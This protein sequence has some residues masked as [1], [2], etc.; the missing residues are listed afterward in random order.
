MT[1]SDIGY[2]VHIVSQFVAASTT[3][4]WATALQMF[5]VHRSAQ[6]QSLFYPSTTICVL[7]VMLIGL[8]ILLLASP[9]PVFCVFLRD[10]LISWKSKKQYILSRSSTEAEYHAMSMTI[11][12]IVWLCW[13]LENM[14]VHITDPTPLHC[15]NRSVI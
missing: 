2:V 7:I 1:R 5:R 12:E 10:S 8:V 6:F 13:L 4:H 11:S 14:G 15:Y 3:V 9:H